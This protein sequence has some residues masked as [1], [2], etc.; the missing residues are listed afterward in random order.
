[1]STP[2]WPVPYYQ[3]AFRHDPNPGKLLMNVDHNDNGNLGYMF[4]E[5]HDFHSIMAKE[6][7]KTQ[8]LGYIVEAVENHFDIDNYQTEFKCSNEFSEAYVDD[9]LDC[10]DL[11]AKQDQSILSQFNL[12][13]CL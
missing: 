8:G 3:R 10:L 7:L 5:I 2:T 1:M 4:V 12:G 11:V 6:V 9:M 13:D